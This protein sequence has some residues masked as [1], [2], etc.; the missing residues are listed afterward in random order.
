MTTPF[1]V[2]EYCMAVGAA[3]V[4]TTLL[5]AVILWFYDNFS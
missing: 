1:E 3:L 2:F 5:V 4:L